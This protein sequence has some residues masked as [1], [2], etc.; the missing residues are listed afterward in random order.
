MLLCVGLSVGCN[1]PSADGDPGD[2][3]N[4]LW[5]FLG[6][7]LAGDEEGTFAWLCAR[8]RALITSV[9]T[10]AARVAEGRKSGTV[11]KR[12]ALLDRAL[13]PLPAGL[14]L[15]IRG[16]MAL[17]RAEVADPPPPRLVIAGWALEREEGGYRVCLAESARGALNQAREALNRAAAAIQRH[18]AGANLKVIPL[19]R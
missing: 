1:L 3:R 19:A 4:A 13:G 16:R 10:A 8:D 7:R 2:P 17:A 9:E 14:K 18:E 15:D 12:A 5:A 6:A 11:P